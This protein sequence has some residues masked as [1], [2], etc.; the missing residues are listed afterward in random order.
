[1]HKTSKISIS[2][3]KLLEAL[4]A[5]YMALI[6]RAKWLHAVEEELILLKRLV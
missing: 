2:K 5:F 6:A 3:K 1:V 4:A